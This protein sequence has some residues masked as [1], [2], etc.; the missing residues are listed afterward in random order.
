[1]EKNDNYIIFFAI[2]GFV[3]LILIIIILSFKAI[4]SREVSSPVNTVQTNSTIVENT[5]EP[6]IV[7][8]ENNDFEMSFL[9]LENKKEN[10]VYSPL[11]I[12]TA[13]KMLEE[14]ANGKTKEEVANVIKGEE[15]VQYEPKEEKISFA[16]GMFVRDTYEENIKEEYKKTLEKYKA[17]I[18][19]DSFE[20]ANNINE[21][22][23]EKTLGIIV[24]MIEDTAVQDPDLKLVLLNALAIDLDWKIQFDP[25]ETHSREFTLD[26]GSKI[27]AEMMS[28]DTNSLYIKY[29]NEHNVTAVSME[30]EDVDDTVLEFIA[31]MPDE[32]LDEY[33]KEFDMKKLEDEI[34]NLKDAS[35][36]KREIEIVIPKFKYSYSLDFKKDLMN[37]GINDAFSKDKADLKGI[38][39][40]IDN[41]YISE[42]LH[43]AD[44][45]FSETGIKAAAVTALFARDEA[46]MLK[47]NPIEIVFDKPFIY[48]IRDSK[49][50]EV[51]FVGTMYEP[52]KWENRQVPEEESI[53]NN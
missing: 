38:A 28:M 53:V 33:I 4:L 51:W 45:E 18:K 10:I 44:V 3:L 17:E 30:L 24:N 39:D 42:A 35:N 40:V 8:E 34:S 6:T 25:T 37:L 1:M 50:G 15:I 5:V 32:P 23:K 11:S 12:K 26:D 13:L 46:I 19:V 7:E 48:F 22:I 43:K 16:N 49:N 20:N 2:A 9:K 29:N 27:N 52:N 14:G 41:L 36:S 21:W 47:E 31:I